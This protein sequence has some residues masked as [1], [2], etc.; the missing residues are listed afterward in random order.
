MVLG[1]GADHGRSTDVDVFDGIRVS[2]VRFGHGLRERVEIHHQQV[3]GR[4]VVLCH[5][6]VVDAAPAQ[7]AAMHARVQGLDPPVHDLGKAGI[8]ADVDYRETC[9]PQGAGGAARA[10][11][12]DL[13]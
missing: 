2:A 11:Q 4:Y 13:A 7:E 5:N 9:V 6:G 8:G 12:L 3:D 10:Q 1:R